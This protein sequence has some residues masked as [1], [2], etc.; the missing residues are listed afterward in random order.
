MRQRSSLAGVWLLALTLLVAPTLSAAPIDGQGTGTGDEGQEAGEPNAQGE[1][2]E[3]E[4]DLLERGHVFGVFA[5]V[6]VAQS[7]NRSSEIDILQAG[8][9]WSHLWDSTGDGF[10]SGHPALGVELLPLIAFDQDPRPYGAGFNLL[11]EHHF[12]TDGTFIPV[13]RTGAGFIYASEETPPR[14]TRHNFSLLA[15]LGVEVPLRGRTAVSLE[16]RLHHVSNAD[17]GF[18]NP[19]INAHTI[20]LGLTFR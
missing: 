17:T 2:R 10:V 13:L 12:D 4:E 14:E 5:S 3:R 8:F 6:G 16:Y 7:I 15:G 20:V 1:R 18:R 9:R 19:G 11:Y